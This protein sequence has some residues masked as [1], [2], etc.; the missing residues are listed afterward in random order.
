M[1]MYYLYIFSFICF[2]LT[3]FPQTLVI[4]NLGICLR[5]YLVPNAQYILRE[6]WK[7]VTKV[8]DSERYMACAEAW[9]YFIVKHFK[10][11]NS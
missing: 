1:S 5:G 10:V 11:N 2:L 6:A 8:K 3:V 9:I 7:I 4:Q